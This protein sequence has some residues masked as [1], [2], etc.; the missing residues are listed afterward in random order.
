M[1]FSKIRTPHICKEGQIFS[2]ASLIYSFGISLILP[3][4]PNFIESIINSETFVGYFYSSMSVSMAIAGL[5]TS[6]FYKKFSRMGILYFAFVLGAL[7][8]MSFVF[9]NGTYTLFV[10]EFFRVFV[11]MYV[12]MT[13]ALLVR[14]FAKANDLGKTEGFYFLFSNIGWFFGPIIGGVIA[15][16]A[17]NEPVFVMSGISLIVGLFYMARQHIVVENP[18]LESPAFEEKKVKAFDKF[19]KFIENKN[20]I[21]SYFIS[22][23]LISW[24][25]FK[26]VVIPLF[27][28][29]NGY[30]SDTTG[31][32]IS[33]CILPYIIFEMPIGRYADKKGLRLP[34]MSG[35]FIIAFFALATYFSPIFY[36]D[37]L[38]L[39][40]ANIGAAFI[41]PLRDVYFFTNTEKKDEDALYG[42]FITADPIGRFIGPALVSTSLIL[43]PFD[44]VFVVFAVL[45]V[46]AGCV[47]VLIK[48]KSIPRKP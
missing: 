24:M 12:L 8:T 31:L 44:Y 47:S 43:L 40:F 45:F 26:T 48:D 21:V 34:I 33:L 39:I 28:A 37:A 25:A 41:E 22:I 16:Y 29:D 6:F 5:T 35:F 23:F 36:L 9:V 2:W 20:R 7:L 46:V 15:R 19:K 30:G 3:I 18:S 42:V 14:D 1:R 13:L 4:F 10:L 11:L 17:G 38:F 27:V 32:V